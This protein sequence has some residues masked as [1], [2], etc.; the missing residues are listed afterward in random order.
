M[1]LSTGLRWISASTGACLLAAAL[2]S[3][4]ASAAAVP[5]PIG[6]QTLS[7]GDTGAA[8]RVLQGDLIQ[9]GYYGGT[10]SG[11][12]SVATR[13]ALRSFQRR[14]GLAATGVLNLAALLG[15]GRT[16]GLGNVT[17]HCAGASTPASRPRRQVSSTPT[18]SQSGAKSG[19]PSRANPASGSQS[20]AP[21]PSVSGSTRTFVQGTAKPTISGGLQVGGKI[22]GLT[23]IRVIHLTATGY[24]ATAQDNYPYG[25][26]DAFGKPLRPG[27]V[28]VDPSVIKLNTKMYVTGYSTPYLPRGG[29]LA[30]ARDTG[31][32][33]KGARIDMYIN[34]TNESL[35]SSFGI[36]HVTAYLLS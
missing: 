31:G 19:V 6:C 29:E 26:T 18:P 25:P 35:I 7:I 24:G 33:I 23:I 28:A 36:Q 4:A 10:V 2:I 11:T 3:P 12:F 17:P 13:T 27:D 9:L 14:H 30:V 34:S 15:I 5:G 32:A 8:V 20:K 1:R 21:V 16:M 22:D